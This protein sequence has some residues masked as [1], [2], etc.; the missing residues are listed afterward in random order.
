MRHSCRV[1]DLKVGR[2]AS[3]GMDPVEALSRDGE[4]EV[5][6]RR[7]ASQQYGLE[8][9]NWMGALQIEEPASSKSTLIGREEV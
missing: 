4:G 3:I 8:T 1:L 9:G 2:L 6:L 7:L 5:L